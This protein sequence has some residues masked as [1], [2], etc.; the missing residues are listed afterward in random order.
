MSEQSPS[1]S[2]PEE[3]LAAVYGC[4]LKHR[5]SVNIDNAADAIV[6]KARKILKSEQET[7]AAISK[8]SQQIIPEIFSDCDLTQYNPVIKYQKALQK[9]LDRIQNQI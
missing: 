9:A 6:D 1:E 3:L 7:R 2:I 4:D 8:V 5:S